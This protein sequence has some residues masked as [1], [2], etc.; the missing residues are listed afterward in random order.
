MDAQ[1]LAPGETQYGKDL[2]GRHTCTQSL[3]NVLHAQLLA[4]KVAGQEIIICFGNRLN[5]FFTI[6]IRL[7]LEVIGNDLGLDFTLIALEHQGFHRQQ[8][9][10]PPKA[11][12]RANRNVNRGQ[13]SLKRAIQ[14][15]DGRT[16]LPPLPVHP[17][18]TDDA[19]KLH[20]LG[21]IP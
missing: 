5:Q 3:G 13:G 16:E 12:L 19:R 9:N 20:I 7:T 8:V 10:H 15:I 1:S 2:A 21:P 18:Q 14:G 17:G 6:V 11:G 4:L